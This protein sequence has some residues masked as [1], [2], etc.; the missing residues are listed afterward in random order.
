MMI[1]RGENRLISLV[2]K[3]KPDH[4]TIAQAVRDDFGLIEEAREKGFYW[5]EISDALGFPGKESLIRAHYSKEKNREKEKKKA[6][7]K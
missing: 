2:E 7:E 6:E 3:G 5:K 4:Q 1:V